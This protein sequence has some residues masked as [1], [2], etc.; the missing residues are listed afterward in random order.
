MN[1]G[2]T[3]QNEKGRQ[4]THS[5]FVRLSLG[6]CA[7]ALGVCACGP[8]PSVSGIAASEADAAYEKFDSMPESE[9]HAA[10]VKAA[11]DEGTVVAYL[12]VDNIG[13]EIEAAFEK[14]YPGVD[15]QIENPGRTQA[16]LQ[17]IT[18]QARAGRLSADVVETYVHELETIY[19]EEGLTTP[20]PDFLK[21]AATDPTLVREYSIESFQYVFLPAWNTDLV[22]ATD[23]PKSI[24]D[25]ADPK[26]AGKLVMVTNYAPWYKATFDALTEAGMSAAEFASKFKAIAA[27]SS[28][29]ESSNPAAQGLASG[30]YELAPNIAMV[31]V[32]RLKGNPPVSY[33][34]PVPP[35][36]LTPIGFG[37]LRG[38]PHPAAAMLFAEWYESPEALAILA[39]EM[40]VR[41]SPLEDELKGVA[42]S[43]LN[44]DDLTTERLN[45]WIVA[46][47]NLLHGRDDVLPAYVLGE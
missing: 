27:N 46:Y 35:V 16:V 45:E 12:R 32:Q 11:Q 36:T 8:P 41:Q 24:T 29:V 19:P 40:Y 39:E 30:Q 33:V 5:L 2:K 4:M 18:E 10:L 37:L 25:L 9:R 7:I 38:A 6:A 43:T 47:D 31:T 44:V 14:K 1:W 20:V 3:R 15:L 23:V 28:I 13:P 34:P 22:P 26:W 42:I 21:T 17:Q